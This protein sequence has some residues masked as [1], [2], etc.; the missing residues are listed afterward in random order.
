[1]IGANISD[2][3]IKIEK[4][5]SG[6]AYNSAPLFYVVK[7]DDSFPKCCVDALVQLTFN[8]YLVIFHK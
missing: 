6:A 7:N 2:I 1:M 4:F 8:Q 3:K 5:F